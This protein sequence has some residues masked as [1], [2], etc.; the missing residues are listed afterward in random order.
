MTSILH[1]TGNPTHSNQIRKKK[2][3]DI[4]IGKEEVKLSLF[5]NDMVLNKEDSKDSTRKA[6]E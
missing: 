5:A 3:K 2:I 4:Q 6:L 1:T